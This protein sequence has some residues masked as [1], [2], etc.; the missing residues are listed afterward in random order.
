MGGLKTNP[1]DWTV[2]PGE[3]QVNRAKSPQPAVQPMVLS[4]EHE[5]V[6]LGDRWGVKRSSRPLPEGGQAPG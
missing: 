5:S 6:A 1:G 2:Q 4:H 3:T